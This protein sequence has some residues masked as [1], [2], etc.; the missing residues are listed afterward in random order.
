MLN[1]QLSA[2]TLL[3]IVFSRR[4]SGGHLLDLSPALFGGLEC[5][6][7]VLLLVDPGGG[8]P[9]IFLRQT[10]GSR[11]RHSCRKEI[12]VGLKNV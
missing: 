11:R 12:T 7:L 2:L 8:E 9:S 6:Q 3:I 4:T 5:P 1:S 10:G